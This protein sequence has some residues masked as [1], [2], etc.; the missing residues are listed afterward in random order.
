MTAQKLQ[1]ERIRLATD[2]MSKENITM[3]QAM[4]K[5][6]KELNT[7]K[8]MNDIENKF[9]HLITVKNKKTGEVRT[10][11][12]SEARELMGEGNV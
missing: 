10:M 5:A 1:M 6:D 7:K 2:Y 9:S 4:K 11:F 12:P 3:P 8:I